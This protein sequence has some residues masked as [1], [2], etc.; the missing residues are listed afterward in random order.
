MT[1]IVRCIYIQGCA[2]SGNTLMRELCT[3]GFRDAQL[4]KL[5]H[6]GAECSLEYVVNSLQKLRDNGQVLTA[7]R[8]RETSLAMDAELLRANPG[9]LV[10]WMLRDP[11]DVLTSAH[12][13]KPGEYHVSPE[14]MIA[15][16]Q[17]YDR[18]KN[19][20]QVLSV[21][22]EDLVFAPASV[23]DRIAAAFELEPLRDFAECHKHF[24]RIKET[25]RAL[26]SIRPI[27]ADS[28]GRWK[29]SPAHREYLGSVLKKFPVLIP[30]ARDCGYEIALEPA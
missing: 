24:S 16:L 26:H 15:S 18:F 23:Q 9:V 17:L 10:L 7:S 1:R 2:R 25:I 22:Y 27:D 6:N 14:R 19:E 13:G 29:K 21:R 4:L 12:G 11:L 5:K 28:V 8:D 30:L 3:H 20:E